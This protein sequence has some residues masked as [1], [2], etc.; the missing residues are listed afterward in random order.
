MLFTLLILACCFSAP[1]EVAISTDSIILGELIPF[2]ASDARSNI[3]L[4]YAPNPGLA[5]RFMRDEILAKVQSAGFSTDDLRLPDSILVHRRSQSLD[6]EQATR[7]IREAFARQY[8]SGKVEIASAEIPAVELGGGNVEMLAIVPPRSDPSAPL[9]VK[10]DIRGSNFVRTVYVRV[11]ARIDTP[12]PVIVRP[13]SAQS[14]V[15]ADDVEW[16][17]T[18]QQGTHDVLTSLDS[19]QGMV[20][21]RDLEPGTILSPDVLYMPIYVRRGDAVVVRA[22]SGAVTVSATMRAREAGK[23]GD[24]IVVEHLSGGG[25]TT[26]RV[27]G[28]RTLE[29]LQ[30]E[31]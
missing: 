28:P 6:R 12:Q 5:R 4:G 8:P 14:R 13:I 24:S 15:L 25:S 23:F 22:T 16:R 10:L 9:L 27:V 11:I 3:Q 1:P 17:M 29:A 21:K 18:P 31:K 20:A 2:P 7:A 19:I 30:E 26:A